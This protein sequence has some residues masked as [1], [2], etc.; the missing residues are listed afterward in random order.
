VR[1]ENEVIKEIRAVEERLKRTPKKHPDYGHLL[2]ILAGL[3]AELR[4]IR[5]RGVIL[6]K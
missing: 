4:D 6:T 5:K 2:T 1:T 3:K